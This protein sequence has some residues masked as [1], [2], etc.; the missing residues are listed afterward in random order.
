[1][2]VPRQELEALMVRY[3]QGDPAAVTALVETLS[4]ALHR[5]FLGQFVSRR[6]A[7]DLLQETWLKVHQVRH[8]YRVGEPVLP[9]LYAIARHTRVDHFRKVHRRD[10]REL[11]VDRLPETPAATTPD[12]SGPDIDEMLRDLPES[13]REVVLMLKVA[14][15]SIEEVAR[16]TGSTIGSVKQKAHRAYEK[17]RRT[18]V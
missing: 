1:V 13:Q 5:F 10:Q 17:L 15:M 11:Q 3:Q 14:E 4:P 7:D 16:A 9:W 8:T 2:E 12:A 6:F 18:M